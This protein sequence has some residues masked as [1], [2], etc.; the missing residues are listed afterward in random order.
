MQDQ[1]TGM[2]NQAAEQ[3]MKRIEMRKIYTKDISYEAP[4]TP[5]IFTADWTPQLTQEMHNSH[6]QIGEDIYE[7]VLTVTIT[8]KLGDKTAYLIEVSQAGIF[9]MPGHVDEGL[10]KAF[11]IFCPTVLFPYVREVISDLSCRGGFPALV[12]PNV[13][14]YAMYEEYVRQ[15]ET[16]QENTAHENSAQ[17]DEGGQEAARH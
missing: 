9:Y 4:G 1:G 17:E 6:K 11:G 10:E 15:K 7:S 16:S 8:V 12:L 14:F 2:D 5:E 3:A 13:N